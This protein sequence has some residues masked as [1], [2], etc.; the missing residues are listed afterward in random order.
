MPHSAGSYLGLHCLLMPF[1]ETRS[2]N[3]LQRAKSVNPDQTP[4]NMA[5]DQGLQYRSFNSFLYTS[6]VLR[7]I[8][9]YTGPSCSNLMSLVN[10]L[11]KL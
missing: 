2:I 3:G 10:V 9:V 1:Y 6:K 11:L 4:Q 7:L 8:W 5:S